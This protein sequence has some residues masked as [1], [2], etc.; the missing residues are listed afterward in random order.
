MITQVPRCAAQGTRP[1]RDP[2]GGGPPASGAGGSSRTSRAASARRLAAGGS[3]IRHIT[4]TAHSAALIVR[5]TGCDVDHLDQP[6]GGSV[7]RCPSPL[8]ARKD[9][10]QQR[11]IAALNDR[12]A[13]GSRRPRPR[14]RPG[15]PHA[16]RLVHKSSWFT[17]A[18]LHNPHLSP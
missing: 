9:G 14:G 12:L 4:R 17:T 6:R 2:G 18:Y 8:N 15:A 5:G 3:V 16:R 1:A 10:Y 13:R 11:W 7:I